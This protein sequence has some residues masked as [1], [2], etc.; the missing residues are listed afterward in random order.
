MCAT[1]PYFDFLGG[2]LMVTAR[3]L[4]VTALN[5]LLHRG[6]VVITAAHLP[7]A[8]SELRFYAGSKPARGVSEICIGQNL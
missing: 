5:F 8:K 7:S 6:L 4:V 1:W 3:Y 2:Y